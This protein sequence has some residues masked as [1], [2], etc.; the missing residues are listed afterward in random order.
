MRRK[1][2]T[3]AKLVLPALLLLAVAASA[4]DFKI[5][6]K[7][8]LVV[9]P[10]TVKGP[11]DKLITGLTKDDF[12]V[13]E[14]GRRQT[15]ANFT[16]DPAP[17]SAAVVVD[18]GLS[19]GSLSKVQKTFSALA[20]AFSE[21]D[22][23]AVYRYDKFVT[24]VL[25]FSQDTERVATAMNTLRDLKPDTNLEANLPGGPFSIPRPVING[26]PVVPP[27]KES[28]SSTASASCRP[29]IS[30][31]EAPS[32]AILTSQWRRDSL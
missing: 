27:G 1:I 11:G 2:R 28:P 14:D 5:R 12:V 30:R 21:Y 10:V 3:V 26:A 15:I 16:S 22:E 13:I 29:I 6:A 23:V 32:S 17:L 31:D 9:V 25:D 4:Q 24:K 8:D 18:T 19:S 20:G 7:V